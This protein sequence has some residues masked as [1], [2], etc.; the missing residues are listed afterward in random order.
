MFRSRVDKSFNFSSYSDSEESEYCWSDE[1]EVR[2]LDNVVLITGPTG[3]GKSG[4]IATCASQL[5]YKV[6]NHVPVNWD[7][8]RIIKSSSW[9]ALPLMSKLQKLTVR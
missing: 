2:W 1:E 3:V 9:I 4:A 6:N 8:R 7:I 5:G